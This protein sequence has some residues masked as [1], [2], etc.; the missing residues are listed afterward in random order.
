MAHYHNHSAT[1]KEY[2]GFTTC[3]WMIQYIYVYDVCTQ[4]MLTEEYVLPK[5]ELWFAAMLHLKTSE[6]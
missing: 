2:E 1:R 3:K 6:A 4:S 5:A